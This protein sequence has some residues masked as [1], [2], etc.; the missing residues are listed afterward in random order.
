MNKI[1]VIARHEFLYTVRRKAFLFMTLVFPALMV[2]FM[3]LVAVV[4]VRGFEGSAD[5]KAVGVVDVA[6][7]LPNLPQTEL[8]V[9]RYASE[10]TAKSALLEE[11]IQEYYI[12]PPDYLATG[13]ILR[14]STRRSLVAAETA[15]DGFVRD[16]A[17]LNLIPAGVSPEV[18]NRLK[19]PVNVVSIRL[20]ASGKAE[21]PVNKAS[22]FLV[23]YFFAFLLMMAIFF[24]SG[25]LLQGVGEEKENRIMEVL[26]SSVSPRQLLMGKVAG[27]GFA[28]L[29]QIVIWLVAA[30]TALAVGAVNVEFLQGIAFPL[31]TV[32]LSMAYFLLGYTFYAVVMAGFGAIATTPREGQQIGGVFSF[33]AIIPF[34]LSSVLIENPDGS[35]AMALT[36]IP[37]TA[38]IA[39]MIR[40]ASADIVI[41][42][43][44]ASL[45]ILAVST[46]IAM[47]ASAKIF[48]AY[49][50]MYGRRPGVREIVASLRAA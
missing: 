42:Q 10:A 37:F 13:V 5:I 14:Y 34:M 9:K 6:D 47:W 3:A 27:L 26:L 24:S 28:G 23:P 12:V 36:F 35:L 1:T 2:G 39:V 43:V 8:Q 29:L 21:E 46:L 20:S 19:K 15:E 40:F 11:T 18:A 45:S 38:P 17:L 32:I 44:A 16:L 49:L 41:W 50:L 25:Y 33:M 22:E 4:S 48:R 7:L 30:R 31:G